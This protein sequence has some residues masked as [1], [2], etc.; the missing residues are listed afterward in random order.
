MPDPILNPSS[1]RVIDPILSNQ[2]RG[3]RHAD[4]VGD[5]LFPRAYVGLSGGQVLEFGKE[6]FLL[7]N[8][9]RAPGANTRRIE[10][11]YL[12]KPYALLNRGLE[13]KLPR[14]FIRDA[15]QVPGI[16]LG[17]GVVTT[18]QAAMSLGVEYEQ[19]AMATD[20]G[21][22]DADHK[23]T[24]AGA[25][26]W[27]ADTGKPLTDIADGREAVRATTGMYPNTLVLSPLAWTAARNNPQVLERFKYT[28]EGP[29]TLEQFA[30][31]IEIANVV[32]GK[33][34]YA[35]DAGAFHD[36]WG[37][38]AVMAYVGAGA[39]GDAGNLMAMAEPSFGYT[40]TMTGHPA[41]EQPYWDNNTKSWIYGVVEESAPVLT[42][43]LAGFL[44]QNPS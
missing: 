33:R 6:S 34:T 4:S 39:G 10:F 14:E 43:I 41:V 23:N 28:K 26:K 22:Y 11:G 2:A 3:Y 30:N 44:I 42:G 13:G 18:T 38:N 27:S 19:A 5:R 17:A 36:V 21:N 8:T 15:A 24:L 7:Y 1:V 31:L 35:D 40:Y 20:A 16:D 9:R 29:V 12:G 37:N 25:D 32:V